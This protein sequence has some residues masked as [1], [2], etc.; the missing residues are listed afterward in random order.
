[1]SRLFSPGLYEIVAT[2]DGAAGTLLALLI[3]KASGLHDVCWITSYDDYA[4][5]LFSAA[6]YTPRHLYETAQARYALE[7]A[8]GMDRSSGADLVVIDSLAGMRGVHPEARTIAADVKRAIIGWEPSI[9][10]LVVNQWR[11]PAPP[12][13]VYWRGRVS[14]RT[15]DV[16]RQEPM[17]AYLDD[18]QPG[19]PPRFLVWYPSYRPELR[20]LRSVEWRY[21]F[22]AGMPGWSVDFQPGR[23]ATVIPTDQSPGRRPWIV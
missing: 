7:T 8:K 17:I 6:L 14:S 3:A 1:M 5:S 11:Y 4:P 19:C 23:P 2:D 9:P 22:P 18:F 15:I 13:G 12:G 16:L 21:F 10:V 20:P